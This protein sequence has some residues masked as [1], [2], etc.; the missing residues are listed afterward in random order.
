MTGKI[1]KIS[2]YEWVVLALTLLFAAGTLLWFQFSRP[3]EGVTLV[4]VREDRQGTAPAEKPQ[5]PGMLEGEV[6]DLNTASLSD[7]YPPAGDRRDQSPGHPHL[8]GDLRSLPGG[9]GPAERGG[10]WGK[11]IGDPAALYRR[12]DHNRGRRGPGWHGSWWLTMKK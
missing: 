12:N 9:G 5:A 1:Q 10:H 6:L 3:E 4:A 11:D 2:A 7:F 8:A